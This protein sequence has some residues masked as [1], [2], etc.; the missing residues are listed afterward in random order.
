M[1]TG[2]IFSRISPAPMALLL[3]GALLALATG[4]PPPGD[5]DTPAGEW[6]QLGGQVSPAG[7]EAEDPTMLVLGSTPAVGYRYASYQTNLNLWNGSSWGSNETDPSGGMTN[8]SIYGTPGFCSQ[9]SAVYM[10]YSHAGDGGSSGAEFYDRVFLYRWTAASHWSAMNGGSEVSVPYSGSPPSADAWEPAVA[11]AASGNPMVAWVETQ[12]PTSDADHALVAEVTDSSLTRSSPLSRNDSAGSFAT[13]VYTVG[14]AVDGSGNAYVAHWEQ[15]HDEQD[16]SDLYVTRYSSGAFTNLGGSLGQD[17]DYTALCVPSLDL[18]ASG[19]L[20]V[21]FTLAN[22]TDNTRHVYVYRYDGSWTLLGGGPVSA[23]GAADHYDSAN[24]DVLLAG[25]TPYVAWE[26]SDQSEGPFI[27]VAF[28][29]EG[30]GSWILDGDRLNIDT[31][32]G[33]ADPD[34]AYSASDGY[35]YVAFEENTDGWY[36]IFVKRKQLSP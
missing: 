12:P 32:N 22:D 29:D 6:S 21:A 14:I 3:A 27:Y 13:D 23:Y 10:A 33:A 1:K 31:M 28:W 35:L 4:C 25:S 5:G 8:S 15:H 30:G 18:D 19:N 26:E 34:L 9:G 11:C 2:K 17:Y 20:Y 24:P 16:R 7:A 36:H